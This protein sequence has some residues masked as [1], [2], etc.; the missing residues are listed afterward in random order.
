MK[1]EKM[2][3]G[4]V[5]Y[6]VHSHKMGNTTINTVGVWSVKIISINLEKQTVQASWNSNAE[7]TYYHNSWSKWRG[8]KPVLIKVGWA[9]RLATREELKALKEAAK[10]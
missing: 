5:V 6:D 1:L 7:R 9:H 4:Q 8:K 3:P 10:P 2:Q